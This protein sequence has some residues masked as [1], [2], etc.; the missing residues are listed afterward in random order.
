MRMLLCELNRDPLAPRL[1]RRPALSSSGRS[2][3]SGTASASASASS[4]CSSSAAGRACT[5]GTSRPAGSPRTSR[6]A[7]SPSAARSRERMPGAVDEYETLAR[8]QRDLARADEGPRAAERRRRDRARAVRAGPARLR[9]RLGPAQ[10]PAVPRLRRGRFPR[11]RLLQRR[12]LRP[13]PGA[14]GGDARVDEDRRAGA[15]PARGH[16]RRAVDRGR[17]AVRA[18]AAARAPHLDGEP[19]PPLQDRHRGLPRP[20]GRGLRRR[21]ESPRGEFGCY[22]VSDGGPKPW[23]VKFRAPSFVALEAT[24]TCMSRCARRRPDR[25]RRLAR[26][27]HGRGATGDRRSTTRC[28][29]SRRSIRRSARPSCPRSGSRR[30]GTAAGFRRRRSGGRGRARI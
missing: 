19:H 22:V 14:H 13:L 17:P 12:R 30:S 26:H 25:H 4:T 10:E 8:P 7:S 11:P 16:A 2:R 1:A 15:R 6:A 5:R 24:A 21:L 20:R 3:C 18:A 23:R 29:R 9:R 27:G 28:R